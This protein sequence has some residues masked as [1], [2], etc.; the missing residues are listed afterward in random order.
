MK[1]RLE[2]QVARISLSGQRRT[3][4]GVGIAATLF[5]GDPCHVLIATL[6]GSART[7]LKNPKLL[8]ERTP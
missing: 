8:K 6:V 4:R 3:L 1:P 2:E 7:N 5:L